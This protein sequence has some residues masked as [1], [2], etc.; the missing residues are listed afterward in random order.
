VRGF[1]AALK[2]LLFLSGKNFLGSA[3]SIYTPA[4]RAPE[5]SVENNFKYTRK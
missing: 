4:V 1:V 2:R 5:K 3:G